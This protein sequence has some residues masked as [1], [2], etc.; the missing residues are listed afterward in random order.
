MKIIH[1][2]N[3]IIVVEKPV[4]VP[5]Q[6]DSSGDSDL[7]SQIKS[8]IKEKYEKPGEVFLGMVH[9]LDRPAGGLLVFAKTSKAASRLSA[10]IKKREMEKEYL[11]VTLG[12][13]PAQ[14]G[15]LVHYITRVENRNVSRAYKVEKP[16]AKKSVL[17]YEVLKTKGKM[18]LVKVQLVTGRQHQIR[19][20]FSAIG[21][22][23][24]GDMKYGAPE[25]LDEGGICLFASRISFVHPVKKEQVTFEAK[26]PE[27][28]PL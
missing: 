23:V 1:E 11:I 18:S 26:P 8:Y 14:D 3:H 12:R 4:G 17:Y 6:P 7:L 21:H 24:I 15:P 28:W 16:N 22:P 19:A 10:L 13:P 9:R 5:T 20:Q 2:D 27:N 25:T